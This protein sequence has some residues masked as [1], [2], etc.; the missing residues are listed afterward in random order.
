MVVNRHVLGNDT[1][2]LRK[3]KE[4]VRTLNVKIE[5]IGGSLYAY[6]VDTDMF[7]AQGSTAEDLVRGILQRC[8]KGSRV[9]CSRDQG[10]ELIESAIKN[11]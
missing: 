7:L 1:A 11:G 8:P 3:S 4:A 10:G 6:T 2:A 5:Q 9:I